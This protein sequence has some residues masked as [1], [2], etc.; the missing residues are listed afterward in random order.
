M[1]LYVC[2]FQYQNWRSIYSICSNSVIIY[3]VVLGGIASIAYSSGSISLM[4]M[5]ILVA[6]PKDEGCEMLCKLCIP[7]RSCNFGTKK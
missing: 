1:H 5:Y 3:S 6:K 7:L 2:T 4:C